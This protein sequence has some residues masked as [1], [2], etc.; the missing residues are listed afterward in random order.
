MVLLKDDILILNGHS[1]P[2]TI[3]VSGPCEFDVPI[4]IPEGYKFVSILDAFVGSNSFTACNRY[5]IKNVNN[6][7]TIRVTAW[8]MSQNEFSISGYAVI[9][10]KRI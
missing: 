10:V 7:A 5:V 6:V 2:K 1:E 8:K 4:T 3:S 9:L